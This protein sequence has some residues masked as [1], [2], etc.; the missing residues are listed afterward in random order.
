MVDTAATKTKLLMQ[1]LQLVDSRNTEYVNKQLQNIIDRL[2]LP[3]TKENL[4]KKDEAN[5]E[6]KTGY[7]DDYY[8]EHKEKQQEKQQENTNKRTVEQRGSLQL[9][10]A[11]DVLS[12]IQENNK[13]KQEDLNHYIE[14]AKDNS[15][16]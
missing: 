11:T 13:R 2:R 4:E 8:S 16:R 1:Q 5:S 9:F 10:P 12:L 7:V 15:K 3:L 14:F 6:K